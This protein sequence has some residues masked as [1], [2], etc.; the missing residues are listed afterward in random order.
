MD[1]VVNFC[2]QPEDTMQLTI[3]AIK[4]CVVE[5]SWKMVYSDSEDAFDKIWAQM[6]QDCIE[7]DGEAIVQWRMDELNKAME[8]KDALSA[9]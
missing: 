4:E 8:I 7:L 1:N 5:A 9:D 2:P 6:I 3:D